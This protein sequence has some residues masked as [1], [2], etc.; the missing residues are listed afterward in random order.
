AE[1]LQ[2]HL[3]D[4]RTDRLDWEA[5]LAAGS[6]VLAYGRR[7]S[8]AL[9]PAVGGIEASTDP[10]VRGW[11][12][13]RDAVAAYFAG[14][15]GRGAD[16]TA[17]AVESI[18]GLGKTTEDLP[19]AYGL[20]VDMAID[21]G[22]R[23]RLEALTSTLEEVPVGQRF[24]LLHGQL[25]RAR[26]HL[27]AEPAPG[28]RAAVDVFAAMGAAYPASVVRVELAARLADDGEARAATDVL[29]NARPLLERIGALPAL[30]KADRVA[31]A[32]TPAAP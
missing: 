15:A 5:Y 4:G 7:D 11:S 6:A 25:L 28:L 8:T 10:V 19:L 18:A 21:A 29:A 3:A 13:M 23:G 1:I 16:M 30:A 26:A 22:E 31:A 9:A 2:R 24:R 14:D 27:S 12:L 17:D 20:A 32:L